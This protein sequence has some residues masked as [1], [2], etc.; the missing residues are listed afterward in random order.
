MHPL[1]SVLELKILHAF[2]YG[3]VDGD[4]GSI[5]T[6]ETY[7]LSIKPLTNTPS[8]VS[9]KDSDDLI[10]QYYSCFIIKPK[11]SISDLENIRGFGNTE[12]EYLIV[13]RDQA[14]LK[15]IN[16]AFGVRCKLQK[17]L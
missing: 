4:I 11:I 14:S 8:I 10:K 9:V 12:V 6:E 15:V 3:L 1:K 17:L 16:R 2:V 13:G 5:K 7:Q